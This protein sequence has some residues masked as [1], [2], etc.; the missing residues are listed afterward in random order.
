MAATKGIDMSDI[1]CA[2]C[3]Q[4]KPIAA[5][6]NGKPHCWECV[7]KRDLAALQARA[8]EQQ[9]K[10]PSRMRAMLLSTR[11]QNAFDS[12]D[13]YMARHAI[14]LMGEEDILQTFGM[15]AARQSFYRTALGSQADSVENQLAIRLAEDDAEADIFGMN[16]S[17][18]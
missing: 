17:K 4:R 11:L 18:Q 13:I 3:Y 6:V 9:K 1:R 5:D 8:W 14:G 16:A 10:L 2:K 12:G 15:M 7:P